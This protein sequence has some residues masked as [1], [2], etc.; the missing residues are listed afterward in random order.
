MDKSVEEALRATGLT[1]FPWD[2]CTAEQALVPVGAG[3]PP[4]ADAKNKAMSAVEIAGQDDYAAQAAV[5]L[6]G[7][8]NAALSTTVGDVAA[9][10]AGW[11]GHPELAAALAVVIAA[12]NDSTERRKKA[13]AATVEVM[14]SLLNHLKQLTNAQ[15]ATV[16][17][18]RA[19]LAA[20]GITP[21]GS[22]IAQ[23]LAAIPAE[24]LSV[25][26]GTP[27]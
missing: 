22:H 4:V 1:W 18:A 27:R 2:G 3:M 25:A 13:K 8:A 5:A 15:V 23:W 19:E 7:V 16:G 6:I 21:N 14:L 9:M 10:A 26:A 17:K 20:L 11:A 24:A 12:G